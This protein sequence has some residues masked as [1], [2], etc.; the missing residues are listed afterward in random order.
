[1][2]DVRLIRL[3]LASAAALVAIG[4]FA[5][6]A[7]ATGPGYCDPLAGCGKHFVKV[8]PRTVKAGHAITVS[9]AVGNW[10]QKPGRA[11]LISRAFKGTARHRLAG[12]PAIITASSQRG[13]FAKKVTI[14]RS[15]K[16]G[17]YHIAGRCG[18]A[19]FGSA[20]LKVTG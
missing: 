11:T 5:A 20:A 8:S 16:A 6:A 17:R 9:G 4:V 14:K 10:C 18:G 13:K 12:L 1:M 19:N 7:G 2:V 3:F 15:V